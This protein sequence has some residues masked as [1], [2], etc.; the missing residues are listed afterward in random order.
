MNL[1]SLAD[2]ERGGHGPRHDRA[3]RQRVV[4]PL[5]A[6]GPALAALLDRPADRLAVSLAGLIACLAGSRRA[7]FAPCRSA[8]PGTAAAP[9]LASAL[10]ALP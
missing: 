7:A 1:G 8:P 4:Y 3:D 5:S 10:A 9:P 6:L 2:D